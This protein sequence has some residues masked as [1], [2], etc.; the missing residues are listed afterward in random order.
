MTGGREFWLPSGTMILALV[1]W[2]PLAVLAAVCL[3]TLDHLPPDRR[4]GLFALFFIVLGLAAVLFGGAWT[5]GL[6]GLVWRTWVQE[7]MSAALWVVGLATGVLTVV[8]ARRWLPEWR[9]GWGTTVV[10]LSVFCLVSAMLVGTV[11]GG[12]WCLGPAE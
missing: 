8:Y 2:G 11:I 12:M 9:K 1:L 6:N 7:G 4:R 5:L 10:D 3:L